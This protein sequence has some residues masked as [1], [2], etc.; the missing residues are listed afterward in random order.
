[1]ARRIGFFICECGPNIGESVDIDA[2]LNAVEDID[3]VVVA[4][5][6]GLMCSGPG[7][8]FLKTNIEAERLTHLVVAA[9]SP[10]QHELTFMEVCESAGVNPF[11]FQLTNIREQV[12]WVTK[13]K[14]E[15]T[16]KTIRLAKAAIRRVRYHDP[17]SKTA[18]EV[19]ADVLVIGGGVAGMAAA[20]RLASPERRV[21]L[22]EM[23]S[24]LGGWVATQGPLYPT[25]ASGAEM[26]TTLV[27][28]VEGSDWI[29]VHLDSETSVVVGFFGNFEVVITSQLQDGETKDTK[30]NVGAVVVATGTD[31][32]EGKPLEDLGHGSIEGVVTSSELEAMLADGTTARAARAARAARVASHPRTSPSSSAWAGT[33]W[34][35][36][37]RCAA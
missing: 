30:V 7:K 4:A 14:V 28:G 1:M 9:C 29:D 19:N 32:L 34:V 27:D 37:P 16:E 2:V 20:Q 25:M 24:A 31:V 21:H 23:T 5:K 15:A 36:A 8:D 35:T 11:L 22:V 17:L 26:A 6:F 33:M 3:D 10:K 18:L 13:D 12:A